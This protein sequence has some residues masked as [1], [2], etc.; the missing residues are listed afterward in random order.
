MVAGNLFAYLFRATFATAAT[1]TGVMRLLR[2]LY[3]VTTDAP[4]GD[5]WRWSQAAGYFQ[6][7]C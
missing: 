2:L 7:R 4:H 1:L 6:R 5:V 3:G